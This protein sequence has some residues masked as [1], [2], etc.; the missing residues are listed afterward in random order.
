MNFQ[1]DYTTFVARLQKSRSSWLVRRITEM[2]KR[3]TT[4]HKSITASCLVY[5]GRFL[6]FVNIYFPPQYDQ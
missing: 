4:T 5:R 6:V 3:S 2:A 1:L